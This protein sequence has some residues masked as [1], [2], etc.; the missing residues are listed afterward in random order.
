MKFG[1]KKMSKRFGIM[2]DMS[3][4]AVMNVDEVKNLA[5]VLK[6]MG[7]NMIQLYM[8]IENRTKFHES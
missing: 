7:Y 2:L 3:R 6:K 4:N 5:V 1:G 8:F